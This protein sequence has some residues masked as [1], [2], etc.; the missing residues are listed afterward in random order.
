MM[1]ANAPLSWRIW[2]PICVIIALPIVG[3]AALKFGEAGIDVLKCVIMYHLKNTGSV[4]TR[5][6]R[7]LR[8]LVIALAPGHQRHLDDLK[9]MRVRLSNELTEVIN[10]YGPKV[11]ED[12]N[13]VH[14]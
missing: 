11:Y 9:Q 1:K 4:F 2:T 7:S 5:R 12:F 14:H 8:P 3:F 13:E 6:Y 10:E